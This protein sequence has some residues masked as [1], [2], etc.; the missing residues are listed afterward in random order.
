MLLPRP[1]KSLPVRQ[2]T[3]DVFQHPDIPI[4]DMEDLVKE[5]LASRAPEDCDHKAPV[6]ETRPAEIRRAWD[7]DTKINSKPR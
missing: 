4:L 1:L 2:K 5:A 3:G 7:C 6:I